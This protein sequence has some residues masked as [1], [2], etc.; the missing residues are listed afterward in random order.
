MNII[1][2]DDFKNCA[3]NGFDPPTTQ[4]TKIDSGRGNSKNIERE[5]NYK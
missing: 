1:N 3:D 5:Q 4:A 2:M